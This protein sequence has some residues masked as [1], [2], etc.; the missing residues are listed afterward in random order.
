MVPI[1]HASDDKQKKR[2]IVFSNPASAQ[3]FVIL[4]Y[5]VSFSHCLV[6]PPPTFPCDENADFYFS[7]ADSGE[8]V[9]EEKSVVTLRELLEE[10]ISD[11]EKS[12]QPPELAG[13]NPSSTTEFHRRKLLRPC[14]MRS[15]ERLPSFPPSCL[16]KLTKP[17]SKG[18]GKNTIRCNP[19]S[20]RT[21][22]N[23]SLSDLRNATN[24]FSN[25]NIIG[26][27]GYAYVYKGSLQDGQ[28]I[29]V[30]QLSRGTP[31]DRISVL[32]SELGIL[33]HV[34]HPNTA[35]LI[36]F[37]VEGGMYLVFQLSPMGNLGSLLHGPN[38]NTLDWSKR[39]F[40]P[41]Y[42]MHGIVNEKTDIYSF[43]V[44]LFEII[45]GRRA[46]DHLKESIMLWAKPLLE[47][48]NIKDL[49]DPSLGDDYDWEQ[50]ERVV[51]TASLCVEQFP[52]LRPRMSQIAILLRGDD[53][54]MEH[55]ERSNKMNTP[56]W[57]WLE[58]F[59]PAAPK[60]I[61]GPGSANAKE[62]LG[63]CFKERADFESGFLLDGGEYGYK[64]GSLIPLLV[65][66]TVRFGLGETTASAVANAPAG[67]DE[68]G[69]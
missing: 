50:M 4:I 7:L 44:L 56:L 13:G 39:Y 48:N 12:Y 57:F 3:C 28:L 16:S 17:K 59:G 11:T 6:S 65:T 63:M 47:A 29:A 40:A 58:I 55:T 66:A 26:R 27:G 24:N 62:G 31:E 42:V 49:V 52:I 21:L 41:E 43:G 69:D 20:S 51:L 8:I 45:T 14:R 37:G 10:G 22:V 32:L 18:I 5:C 35:M 36:G 23:F 34:E 9:L 38:K 46:L 61:W 53:Y 60:Q 19:H 30:K 2:G 54:V 64:K 68:N 67:L 33:S 25:E 1:G 15:I